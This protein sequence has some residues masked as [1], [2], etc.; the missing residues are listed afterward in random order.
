MRERI[1]TVGGDFKIF[2]T[3]ETGT[4]I[5]VTVLLENRAEITNT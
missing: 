2:S 1:E 4:R 3:P 5:E